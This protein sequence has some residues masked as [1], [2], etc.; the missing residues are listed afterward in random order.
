[1]LLKTKVN[2]AR[3]A[4]NDPEVVALMRNDP[5]F[6]R[7]F[8]AAGNLTV[9]PAYEPSVPKQLKEAIAFRIHKMRGE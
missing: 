6:A 3:A 7:F 9:N 8:D 1:M 5:R 4:L 2:K